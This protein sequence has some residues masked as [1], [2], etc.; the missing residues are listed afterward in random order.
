[1]AR[2]QLK[3]LDSVVRKASGRI[4]AALSLEDITAR[5]DALR[6][7]RGENGTAF[8]QAAR[9]QICKML[10]A[11]L[12]AIVGGLATAVGITAAR[13]IFA[14]LA[15]TTGY[16]IPIAIAGFVAFAAGASF[17]GVA[18]VNYTR[19]KNAWKSLNGRID[20]AA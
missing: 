18:A 3:S 14:T 5:T 20:H 4:D 6:S 2:F 19:I 13:S 15:G 10:G 1:V 8:R 7:A 16:S 9:R 11:G 17:L 12:L